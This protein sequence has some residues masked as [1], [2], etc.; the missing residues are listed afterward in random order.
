METLFWALFGLPDISVVDFT[1]AVET[2]HYFTQTVGNLLY[3]TYHVIA[4]VV[5]LNVL[6]AMMSN[7]YTRVEVSPPLPHPTIYVVAD[8][9]HWSHYH[10][11]V[12]KLSDI[13]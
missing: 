9:T 7:T 8:R 13:F 11:Y 6:I 3:A 2:K 1:D 10:G 12:S 4:I 5:L